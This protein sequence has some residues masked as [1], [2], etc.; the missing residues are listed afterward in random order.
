VGAG[1]PPGPG[2]SARLKKKDL[3]PERGA[4]SSAREVEFRSIFDARDPA[5]AK[6]PMFMPPEMLSSPA[7][8]GELDSAEELQSASAWDVATR[9]HEFKS[10]PAFRKIAHQ[11]R[12]LS[13]EAI[14]MKAQ[15]VLGSVT[16]PMETRSSPWTELPAGAEQP[17]IELEDTAE[18]SALQLAGAVPLLAEDIWMGYQLHRRQPVVLT[19]DTSLSMTGEKLALTAV[20]L[21]VV[22]LQFP[23]DP[24]GI[25][26]FENDARVLKRPDERISLQQL[27]E[28]FLDVPAQGYTHLEDG[29]KA[30]LQ[31]V[32]GARASGQGKPPSTVLLTDGKYTA[33][34]D[35]A[36]L[37]VRFPHLVVLKMGKERASLELCRELARKGHGSLQ[38]VGELEALP[39][40]MYGVVKDLLRGRSLA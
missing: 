30:A 24:V 28:R 16:H 34:R 17:D 12:S 39:A 25:V 1:D 18:N 9:Y 10:R 14:L 32:R 33:G 22:L 8:M 29:M 7:G 20:A 5:A 27:L 3:T 23:E 15:E 4:D 36:Y 37:A 31:L 6:E 38:E 2:F 19:V 40:V 35:P 13:A 21:A 26:A 11:L